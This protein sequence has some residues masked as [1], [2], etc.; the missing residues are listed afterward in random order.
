M[1]NVQFNV[2]P[3]RDA[4]RAALG[5]LDDPTPMYRQIGEYLVEATRQR[6]I[7]GEA[8]DGTKWAPK[9]TSTLERY[10]RLG[11]GNRLRPL[12]G[13]GQ[14]LSREI[15]SNASKN[16]AM[17]GSALIYSGVMQDGAAKGA[18]GRDSRG[19]PL[20][21]GNIPARTWLGIGTEDGDRIV[22]I[23]DAFLAAAT[24]SQG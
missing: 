24:G 9:R 11:Y 3:S 13:P 4:I 18:F 19:R 7:R 16:G 2:G 14:R 23:A 10:K 5:Q 8:P 6:F 21:W 17:I 22:T 15:V 1:F 12:I 20:P